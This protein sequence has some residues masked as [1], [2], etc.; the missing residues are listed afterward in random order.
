MFFLEPPQQ[1]IK[2]SDYAFQNIP[3][4]GIVLC[5]VYSANTTRMAGWLPNRF[6][7]FSSSLE[8][9][10]RLQAAMDAGGV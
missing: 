6:S 5:A 7:V 3:M 4:E 2:G 9:L 1:Y 10:E 8:G